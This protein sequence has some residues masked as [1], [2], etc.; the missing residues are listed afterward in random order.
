M[1][2][3]RC[4][5]SWYHWEGN[6]NCPDIALHWVIDLPWADIVNLQCLHCTD[7]ANCVFWYWLR[8]IKLHHGWSSLSIN[9]WL[10]NSVPT[11]QESHLIYQV[12]S[13]EGNLQPGSYWGFLANMNTLM[14][15]WNGNVQWKAHL[16]KMQKCTVLGK[17]VN[18]QCWCLQST[19]Q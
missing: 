16:N 1:W 4:V 10:H 12:F 14:K 3:G 2:D 7:N 18:Y 15:N 8:Q 5:F 11:K 9:A 17:S 6:V 19:K 13:W